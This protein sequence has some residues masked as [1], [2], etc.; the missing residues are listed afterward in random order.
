[1]NYTTYHKLQKPLRTEK[2]DI[3]VPNANADI[4][5]A[6]LNRLAQKDLAQDELFATKMALENGLES[7]SE[8]LYEEV[9]RATGK[10]TEILKLLD[11][12]TKRAEN[13]EREIGE[14][15]D[16]I[17]NT[18]DNK[19]DSKIAAL[20]TA[21]AMA[22]GLLAKEDK[23][24]YDDAIIKKH[25]HDNKVVLD[26]ITAEKVAGWDS[27]AE[28]GSS[29]IAAESAVKDGNGNV[30]ANTYALKS[31]YGDNSIS[32]G[33]AYDVSTGKYSPIGN[34]SIGFG[35]SI[36]CS[37]EN[38]VAI[39]NII[40]ISGNCSAAFGNN[41][42]ITGHR[43]FAAG[44]SHQV[45]G[46][47]SAALGYGCKTA[48]QHSCAIGFQAN[49]P[50]FASYSI[51]YRT[52]SSGNYSF[53]EGNNSTASGESSHAEGYYTVASELASHVEGYE[54][55]ASGKYSHAEGYDTKASG[56]SSH[57]EGRL[58]TASGKSSHAEGE[59]TTALNYQHVQGHCNNTSLATAGTYAGTSAG[60]AFV[61]GNGVNTSS[62]SNA[63]RI[64]YNGKLWCKA[65][66]SATGADYA[67]YFEWKDGNPNSENRIGYFVT[68]DG[69]KIKL[70]RQG[71]YI[72]GI[73]S[74]NP[75]VLG[76]TDTEWNGQYLKDDFGA[77]IIE[78]KKITVNVP[79]NKRDENGEIVFK[80]EEKEILFYKENPNYDPS[81]PYIQRDDRKEWSAVGMIG[82]LAVYDDGTCK[83]NGYC[84]SNDKG[85]ATLSTT[86]YRVIA[87]I[88][89]NIIKVVLK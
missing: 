46:W 13:A 48:G 11:A 47:Q 9:T 63:V 22:D 23:A 7:S 35:E 87:R 6:A 21:T 12:E 37:G 15:V 5:D 71:D 85:I 17:S 52:T 31:V 1:M 81:Q 65:A 44:Q 43:C 50:A 16:E 32:K 27:A 83:V 3:G 62:S 25:E 19:I 18:V 56:E 60:T 36:K 26:G 79:I 86:G 69:D 58:T 28:S 49:T 41:N 74:A 64:D 4:I 34:M 76:N 14:A 73:V 82:V 70:A 45:S 55:T 67:E 54:S 2:Y 88:K 39:G 75:C 20:P 66:Y 40:E 10:E 57:A 24:Q 84:S 77:Y 33:M 68:M 80:E 38:S 51:G 61:I 72:L 30:I 29:S 59:N 78:P 53:S 8:N 42:I 89:D